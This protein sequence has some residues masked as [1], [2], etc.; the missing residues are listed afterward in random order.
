MKKL[1]AAALA[2]ALIW[3]GLWFWQA[4]SLRAEI[5]AWFAE[6][7]AA[8]WTAEA[9][10]ISVRGFPNRLDARFAGLVLAPPDGPRWEVPE[11]QVMQLVYD[12]DHLI[13]AASG[14]QRLV[15]GSGE[16]AIDGEGLRASAVTEGGE[17][18]RL[19]IEARR[20]DLVRDAASDIF[21]RDLGGGLTRVPGGDREWRLSLAAAPVGPEAEAAGDER[22]NLNAQITLDAP[23]EERPQLTGVALAGLDYS[24]GSARLTLSGD[25]EI[26]KGGRISGPLALEA[27]E[28]R[29]L[30]DRAGEEDRLPREAV[31]L[32]ENVFGV[33]AGLSGSG[34][35]LDL[36]LRLDE[37]AVFLGPMRVGKL[38]RLR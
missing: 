29:A 34:D 19:A 26:D 14:G 24:T 13:V 18:D 4:R 17:L 12:P 28:W 37:G 15:T 32:L 22:V 3:S 5:D 27:E 9:G 6:K 33:I 7:R 23:L 36:S 8:G 11:L 2:G 21:L 38:P 1:I 16:I 31:S 20:L 25:F 30:L 35:D 10:D